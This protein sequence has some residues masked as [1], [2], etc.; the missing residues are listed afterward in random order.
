VIW[1]RPG[2]WQSDPGQISPTIDGAVS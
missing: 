1:V 2:E